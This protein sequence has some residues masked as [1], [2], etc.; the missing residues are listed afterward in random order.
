[1]PYPSNHEYVVAVFDANGTRVWGGFDSTGRILHAPI[2]VLDD[3]VQFN[4]DSSA[5]M[6]LKAG[7]IYSW[8]VYADLD[9][10]SP[11]MVIKLISSSEDLRGIFQV[12]P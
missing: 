6:P 9:P 11:G 2:P 10:N 7:G 1:M 8:K 4:F 3:S 5:V 12:V